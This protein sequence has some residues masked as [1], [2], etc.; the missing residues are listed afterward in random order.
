MTRPLA[1][2][3]VVSRTITQ[4]L[5]SCNVMHIIGFLNLYYYQLHYTE[6]KSCNFIQIPAILTL[7]MLYLGKFSSK[8]DYYYY[9]L[10]KKN[11]NQQASF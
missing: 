7:K 1:N 6:E 2:S 10:K 4:Q 9:F 11:S 5:F 3:F 8:S